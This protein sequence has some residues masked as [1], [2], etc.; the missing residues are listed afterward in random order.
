MGRG[1]EAWGLAGVTCME[2]LYACQL[3]VE[4][5]ICKYNDRLKHRFNYRLS[6]RFVSTK[7]V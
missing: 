3:S 1:L 2:Y 7:D 5:K 6:Q 4:L